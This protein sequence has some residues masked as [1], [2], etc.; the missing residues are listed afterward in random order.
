MCVCVS[1]GRTLDPVY[2]ER[3]IFDGRL[4]HRGETTRMLDSYVA[5]NENVIDNTIPDLWTAAFIAAEANGL[6]SVS[7]FTV[8]V[9]VTFDA[10][11]LEQFLARSKFLTKSVL[12]GSLLSA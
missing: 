7:I 2:A 1:K 9:E 11:S 10:I 12:L 4:T 3:P 8:A 6:L 5:V